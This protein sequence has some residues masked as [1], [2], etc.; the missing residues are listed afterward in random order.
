MMSVSPDEAS[1]FA[2]SM[3]GLKF[4][5]GTYA[6]DLKR[7]YFG[8][9]LLVRRRRTESVVGQLRLHVQTEWRMELGREVLVD[10]T[11]HRAALGSRDRDGSRRELDEFDRTV[12]EIF[13]RYVSIVIETSI[14]ADFNLTCRC[15]S[16][17]LLTVK[18]EPF[19]GE[20]WR[21]LGGLGPDVPHLVV[22]HSGG[23][24]SAWFE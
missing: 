19:E 2:R 13:D 1:L 24:T 15:D 22:G 12:A 6:V 10:D 23:V 8:R 21:L 14:D 5:D 3:R 11:R 9:P 20:Q 4:W 7:F 16:G 18:P 17:L